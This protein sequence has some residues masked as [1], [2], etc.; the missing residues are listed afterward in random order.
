M[1][2]PED[3]TES[4]TQRW[5]RRKHAANTCT[6]EGAHSPPQK[7]P[8]ADGE[9]SQ[10]SAETSTDP[11][12]FDPA[13]LPPIESIT[14]TSVVGAFLTPGVPEELARAALRRAWLVDPTIRDFV[15][16]A[17][18]QWDFTKPD[19]VPGF[20]L[21]DLTPELRRMV[22]HVIGDTA[23]P[24]ASPGAKAELDNQVAEVS[25]ELPPATVAQTPGMSDA[26]AG[27]PNIPSGVVSSQ[28]DPAAS[29]QVVSPASK[30]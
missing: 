18:N 21:L 29:P 13:V 10:A 7:R 20:G 27:P 15:G 16:L 5:S 12:A 6:A 3:S 23:G 14:A 2:D 11:P 30:N 17:E 25:P 8:D 24:S 1:S 22:A 4:F 26:A 19:G 28:D 9:P